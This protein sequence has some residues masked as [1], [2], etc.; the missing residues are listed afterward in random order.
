MLRL[1]L[2][3]MKEHSSPNSPDAGG[4]VRSRAA[5]PTNPDY[6]RAIT[7]LPRPWANARLGKCLTNVREMVLR[8]GGEAVYGWALEHGPLRQQGWY[9]PP[10]YC[11]WLH[12]VVWRDPAGTLWEVSPHIR[13][14]SDEGICFLPTQFYEDSQATFEADSQ[15]DWCSLPCKYLAL[16]PE[17]EQVAANLNL[18]QAAKTDADR[19]HCIREALEG[20]R[21]A[22]FIPREWKVETVGQRTGT[23][24]LIA[25]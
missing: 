17:G 9:P 3:P 8:E 23:I 12:H 7:V 22:G 13:F 21:A 25:E 14:E 6:S 4:E 11:R 18:G 1:A 24:W 19:N 2:L 16:R 15:D 10:L 5:P 20:L